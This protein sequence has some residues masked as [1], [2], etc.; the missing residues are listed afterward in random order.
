M[1]VDKV[2]EII[3]FKQSNWLENFIHFCSQKRNQA[4]NFFGKDFSKLLKTWEKYGTCS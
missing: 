2:H 4:V 1:F 3:S